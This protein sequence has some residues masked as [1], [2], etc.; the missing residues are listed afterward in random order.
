MYYGLGADR[1]DYFTSVME[2]PVGAV[3]KCIDVFL[4]GINTLLSQ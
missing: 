1:R 2:H 4:Y 3:I